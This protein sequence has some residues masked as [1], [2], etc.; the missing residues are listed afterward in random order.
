MS[1]YQQILNQLECADAHDY[2]T[3]Q[4]AALAIRALEA[5]LADERTNVKR[6]LAENARLERD[7]AL[8]SQFDD[9]VADPGCT[10]CAY[11]GRRCGICKACLDHDKYEIPRQPPADHVPPSFVPLSINQHFGERS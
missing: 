4:S 3:A 7:I 1:K 11:N 2:E 5:E 10:G 6:L 9:A 8:L